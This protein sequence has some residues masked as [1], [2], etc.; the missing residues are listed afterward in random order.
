MVGNKNNTNQNIQNT[1]PVSNHTCGKL[2][3]VFLG[4]III[5]F[6][7]FWLWDKNNGV[8][9]DKNFGVGDIKEISTS[10]KENDDGVVNEKDRNRVVA[11]S[12]EAGSLA[13]ITEVQV[14]EPTWVAIH[15]DVDGKPANILG[16]QLFDAGVHSGTVALL[17]NTESGRTYHALLY[18]DNGDRVFDYVVDLPVESASE[19]VVSASFA[20]T[21]Q[22]IPL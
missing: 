3:V 9:S 10:A 6:G 7:S 20:T 18:K 11:I 16:A 21:P 19:T 14:E 2:I 12:Q 22:S 4:G 5:G 17:R 8:S 15:E 13:V 1:V